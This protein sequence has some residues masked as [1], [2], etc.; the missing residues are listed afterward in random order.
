M[1]LSSIFILPIL[2]LTFRGTAQI[3]NSDFEIWEPDVIYEKPVGWTT[4]N[5]EFGG[6]GV[7]Q[8]TNAYSG[9]YAIRLSSGT[10]NTIW[11]QVNP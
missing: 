1:K 6:T 10:K 5:G 2:F 3:P 9:N 7:T 8:D 4:N 11:A